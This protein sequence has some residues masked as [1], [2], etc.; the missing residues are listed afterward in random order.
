MKIF[1]I[2]DEE[3]ND[4]IGTLIYYEKAKTFIIELEETLDE[5]SASLLFMPFV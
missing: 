2:M 1:E 4:T 3:N 5:W